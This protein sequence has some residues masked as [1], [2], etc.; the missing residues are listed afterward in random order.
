MVG[1]LVAEHL[2][3]SFRVEISD[4]VA[5]FE[6]GFGQPG[7]ASAVEQFGLEAAP[8]RCGVGA[9]PGSARGRLT[10]SPTIT[11]RRANRF[12]AVATRTTT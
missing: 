8:K 2:V 12:P 7:Q 4:V 1:G 5:G 9:N 11:T 10:R 3:A 6:P